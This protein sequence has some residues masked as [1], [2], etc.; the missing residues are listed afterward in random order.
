MLFP[1][2]LWSGLAALAAVAV[3]RAQTVSLPGGPPAPLVSAGEVRP[4]PA[5]LL[6]QQQAAQHA[7]ELGLPS[8]AAEIYRGLLVVPGGDRNALGLSLATALLD[9][10]RVDEA[11]QALQ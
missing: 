2:C 11:E 6:L 9:D 3:A 1:K 8:L 4:A 5:E 10:G 7:L